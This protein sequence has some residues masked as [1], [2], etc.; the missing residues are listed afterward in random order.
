M[1]LTGFRCRT[2]GVVISSLW[3]KGQSSLAV[4]IF[5]CCGYSAS[6][7][8]LS[9]LASSVIL[10]LDGGRRRCLFVF[11]NWMVS[12]VFERMFGGL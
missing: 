2:V 3:W 4:A 11:S 10:V 6:G 8:C 12:Y 5:I 1:I 9:A 7:I